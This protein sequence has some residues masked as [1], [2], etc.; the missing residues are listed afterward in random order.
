MHGVCDALLNLNAAPRGSVGANIAKNQP[1]VEAL[2][3][4]LRDMPVTKTAFDAARN[5]RDWVSMQ[6]CVL[7]VGPPGFSTVP[8]TAS[9]GKDKDKD[10]KTLY[11]SSTEGTRFFPFARG[12]TNKDRGER[13]DLVAFDPENADAVEQASGVIRPGVCLS[14]FMR[15][16]AFTTD[17]RFFIGDR[18]SGETLAAGSML[19]LQLGSQNV[20]QATKGFLVKFKRAMLVTDT[21]LAGPMLKTLP[22]SITDFDDVMRSCAAQRALARQCYAGNAKVFSVGLHTSGFAIHD[23]GTGNFVLAEG[24]DDC[25]EIDASEAMVYEVTGCRDSASA[26][27]M[28][29]IAIAMGAMTVLVSSSMHDGGVIMSAAEEG[30]PCRALVLYI[31]IEK[32]L[33]ISK[34]QDVLSYAGA[35]SGSSLM[36]SSRDENNTSLLWM[37]TDMHITTP[38]GRRLVVFEVE[39]NELFDSESEHTHAPRMLMHQSY[40]PFR[41]LHMYLLEDASMFG[42]I[43]RNESIDDTGSALSAPPPGLVHV[44][45]MQLRADA[46]G[47]GSKRRRPDL[48]ALSDGCKKQ[49]T[50]DAREEVMCAT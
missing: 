2:V 5:D 23:A 13:V 18:G 47:V 44:I 10:G 16:E 1:D 32:M 6:V 24:R 14:N 12:R 27:C 25:P 50:A 11:E 4:L 9:K 35:E 17:S 33:H 19:F 28:L 29:N 26:V 36:C 45:S 43:K 48:A 39:D 7:A 46:G 40:G 3:V 38:H 37:D 34:L 15:E 49:N 20:E 22:Q 42:V 8:Y 41:A 21:S 30:S 31:D